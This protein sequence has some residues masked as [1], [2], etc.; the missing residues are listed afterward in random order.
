MYEELYS[1]FTANNLFHPSL[2]GYRKNRSTQ[3]ALM[4]LY[5]R[6]VRAASDGKLSGTVLLDLSAAFDLVDPCILLEKLR[7]YRVN[8]AVLTW[9]DSYLRDRQQ[10]VWIDNS[11]SDLLECEVGV[12]QGSNLGP[13]LFL[14][15][16]N[17]L[18][19]HLSCDIEAYAD[20]STMTSVGLTVEE[21]SSTLTENCGKVSRWMVSN[22]LRLN[23]SKTHV[24]T[25]G[26]GRRLQLQTEKVNVWMDGLLLDESESKDEM[27]LGCVISSNLKWH[28]HVL[29]VI[30]KLKGRLFVLQKIKN[31]VP[32]HLKKII[33]EGLFLSVLN[34]CLPLYGG[35]GEGDLN[36]LQVLQNRAARLIT[37]STGRVPRKEVF[38]EI[39][40]MTVRQLIFYQTA[41]T[42]FRI[43]ESCEPE[44]LARLMTNDNTRGNIIVPNTRLSLAQKSYCFRASEQ[45]N[46]LPS[47]IRNLKS[48][49][50]FKAELKK[51]VFQNVE[52][53]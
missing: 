22:R 16:Y 20:D 52:A 45:W 1:Y 27:L 44:Y 41:L 31:I 49:Q 7:L 53:F 13:L 19:L 40:W 15:F 47:T 36:D 32:S 14:I 35:C 21:I 23:A 43:R 38:D 30:K 2:H 26:T 48:K 33:V 25:L 42:T 5:D 39:H 34:Y 4:Q 17:D 8:E 10:T 12:P 46:S 24:L 11:F 28:N 18:P 37:N 51:W 3:T 9:F 6:W 29:E 50:S